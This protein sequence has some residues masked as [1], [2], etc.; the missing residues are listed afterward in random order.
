MTA[1]ELIVILQTVPPDT[2]VVVFNDF[3]SI[4]RPAKV[5]VEK[6]YKTVSGNYSACIVQTDLN[7]IA[8][9]KVR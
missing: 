1:A 9:V 3:P 5:V 4:W 2:P 6:G 8:L 7:N